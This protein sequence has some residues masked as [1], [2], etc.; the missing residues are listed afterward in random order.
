MRGTKPMR[1]ASLIISV[2]MLAV[3]ARAFQQN[4]APPEGQVLHILVNK[5][6]V[7]NNQA[8]V[9]RVLTSNPAAI[10]TVATSPTQIVVSGKAPGNSSLILWDSHEHRSEEHTSELQSP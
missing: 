1:I 2:I 8:P 7:I 6:V 9:M 4:A 10:E 3:P 5:S